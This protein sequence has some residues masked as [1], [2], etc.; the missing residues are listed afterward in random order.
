MT[1]QNQ[2]NLSNFI[3]IGFS[4]L[5]ILVLMIAGVF[6]NLGM[7][8]ITSKWASSISDFINLN[9]VGL[10]PSVNL[11]L[12]AEM[13][14]LFGSFGAQIVYLLFAYFFSLSLA[15]SK[16]LFK[17]MLL[18]G[19][20]LV[21]ITI[22]ISPW[23]AFKFPLDWTIGEA[24]MT[25]SPIILNMFGFRFYSARTAFLTATFE[26]NLFLTV[27]TYPYT[28]IKPIANF[29]FWGVIFYFG[30]KEFRTRSIQV[31]STTIEKITFAPM[32]GYPQLYEITDPQAQ[33][34][35]LITRNTHKNG[36]NLPELLKIIFQNLETEK[37]FSGLLRFVPE[38]NPNLL[39]EA[40]RKL[41]INKFVLFWAPEFNYY[42]RKSKLDALYIMAA[43]GR[44]LFTYQFSEGTMPEAGLVSGMFSA[45]TA[46]IKETTKSRD[47]LRYIDNGDKKILLE[48]GNYVIVALFADSSSA[49][50]RE[51]LAK[52]IHKF[53]E[54]FEKILK[55]WNG[56]CTPFMQEDKLVKEIFEIE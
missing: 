4:L 25:G 12:D 55:R 9:L 7:G 16:S 56:D 15:K 49:E 39:Y 20:T 36:E 51:K 31:D 26:N 34:K 19:G 35:F 42:Y 48:Y 8:I 1:K 37:T 46:F 28:I 41:S 3:G 24:W 54:K 30:R 10:A 21:L 53:E 52:L 11:I 22:I 13:L 23:F 32:E 17:A 5:M 43:D 27:I 6:I 14:N 2:Q 33:Q 47:L 40:L 18:Y 29:G 45:I 38:Q 44:D 50:L